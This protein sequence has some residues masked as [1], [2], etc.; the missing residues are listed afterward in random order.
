MKQPSILRAGLD[1]DSRTLVVALRR[2]GVCETVR[3]LPNTPAGH[4]QLI[5][6]LTARGVSARV[7]WKRRACTAWAWHWPCTGRRAWK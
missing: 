2:D 1:V 7:L 6:L 3:T 5:K 4:R